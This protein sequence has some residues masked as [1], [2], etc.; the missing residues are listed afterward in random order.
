MFKKLTNNEGKKMSGLIFGIIII[1]I[2]L[3]LR[4]AVTFAVI[5]KLDGTMIRVKNLTSYILSGVAVVVLAFGAYQY[6][7]A[8]FLQHVRTIT[9]TEKAVTKTG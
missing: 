7:D 6:N 4:Y 8:G 9:G 5:T 2:A 3:L 1:A